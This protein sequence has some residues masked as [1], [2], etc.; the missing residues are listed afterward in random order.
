MI[1]NYSD[2]SVDILWFTPQ[3]AKVVKLAVRTTM[4]K[5]LNLLN[6]LDSTKEISEQTCRFLW[7]A[8][9]TSL[10]EHVVYGFVISGVSRSLAQQ[11]LRQRT[12]SP[13]SGSQ[14]YQDYHEYPASIRHDM[15]EVG[16][17]AIEFS[18]DAY[19]KMLTNGY[20]KYEAR[21]VLPIGMVSNLMWT[22]DARNLAY[23]LKARLCYRNVDEMGIFARKVKREVLP[24]FPQF[25]KF[26]GPQCFMD[27][28]K[29]GFM[30]CG[31][32]YKEL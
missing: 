13:T 11:I 21:Q 26:I 28:C 17:R 22:I 14:H 23:F 19:E 1:Q 3:P 32:P 8:E 15:P 24:T 6:L 5:E 18:I 4:A 9:H 25:F 7:D 12:A 31:K 16:K 2:M 20:P 10:F 29:Q 30:S 27:K